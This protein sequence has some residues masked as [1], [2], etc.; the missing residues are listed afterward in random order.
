MSSQGFRIN[1]DDI[2]KLAHFDVMNDLIKKSADELLNKTNVNDRLNPELVAEIICEQYTELFTKEFL[3]RY[4]EI[5][6]DRLE[7]LDL[8]KEL[9]D[10]LKLYHRE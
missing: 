7:I 1:L 4:E 10:E 6:S 3:K 9:A 2:I 5:V 8:L